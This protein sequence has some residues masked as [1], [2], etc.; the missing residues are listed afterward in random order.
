MSQEIESALIEA[1]MAA[2]LG[3]VTQYPNEKFDPPTDGT[4]WARVFVSL[5][6]PRVATVSAIG[7]NETRGFLQV[8]FNV[9][10][11]SGRATIDNLCT[12]LENFFTA[13]KKLVYGATHVTIVTSGKNGGFDSGKFYRVPNTITFYARKNRT[14]N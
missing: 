10:L 4:P 14:N 2:G 12:N 5:T 1:Y 7:E 9:P 13:G 11:L 6:Q 8:D 3:V